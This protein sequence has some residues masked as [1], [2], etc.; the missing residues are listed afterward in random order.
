MIKLGEIGEVSVRESE[1]TKLLQTSKSQI[2]QDVHLALDTAKGALSI[3][4][5]YHLTRKCG[6]AS[7]VIAECSHTLG[8]WEE[9]HH[10]ALQAD[11]CFE[12]LQEFEARGR[13]HI[14]IA[15]IFYEQGKYPEA[16]RERSEAA[17]LFGLAT[18][19][20]FPNESPGLVDCENLR[21]TLYV[22][23]GELSRAI[24]IWQWTYRVSE[25]IGFKKG[26]QR[27]IGNLGLAYHQ[28]GNHPEAINYLK[29][30]VDLA[31]EIADP[32]VEALAL[33][34]LGGV[35]EFLD[36]LDRA[37]PYLVSAL[38]YARRSCHSRIIQNAL[39]NLCSLMLKKGDLTMARRLSREQLTI[40]R[41]YD[42]KGQIPESWYLL[43]QIE[44]KDGQPERAI[45]SLR[46]ALAGSHAFRA[47]RTTSKIELLLAQTLE[48][49][50]KSEDALEYFKRHIVSLNQSTEKQRQ[51]AVSKLM[52]R[53][54]FEKQERE[55]ELLHLK[56]EQLQSEVNFKTK[57]LTTIALQLIQN[58]EFLSQLK[59]Q[60]SQLS[61]APPD[62]LRIAVTSVLEEIDNQLR[63]EDEWKR[64]EEQ[65]Q[66]L[67][68]AF[69]HIL[70]ER[71]PQLTPTEL[72]I[73]SLMK[74]NLSSKEI[75]RLLYTSLR[76]IESHR[77]NIKKKLNLPGEMTLASMISAL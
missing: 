41:K 24:E 60:V 64:F 48:Q 4:E 30:S 18:H 31:H 56:T 20:K 77:Y 58:T 13:A 45:E 33:S 47:P 38:D 29:Q 32:A 7:L 40:A 11:R 53:F 55:S 51:D 63:Q 27:A 9:C 2:S 62:A 49:T 44:I 52:T 14:F 5:E 1:V 61:L 37:F 22:I 8:L 65:F 50:G 74:I 16:D 10:A 26:A 72:K 25:K 28:M 3:A 6:E 66:Q 17:R 19:D 46:K 54:E 73:C 71:C 15:G 23:V 57:E 67:H 70:S 12:E 39:S 69:I 42:L 76:T 36:E 35:H 21:G 75:A 59:E 43:A 68:E 34:N